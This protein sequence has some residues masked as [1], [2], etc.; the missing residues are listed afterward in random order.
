MIND[1]PTVFEV[2][3]GAVKNPKDQAEV[4]NNSTKS[5]SSGKMVSIIGYT[6]HD[7]KNAVL[8]CV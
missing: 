4:L 6:T 2:V 7:K 3:S 8:Y 5:K 1:L